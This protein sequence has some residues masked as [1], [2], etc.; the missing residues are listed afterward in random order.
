MSDYC[1][2]LIQEKD[3]DPKARSAAL[4][5]AYREILSW[6]IPEIAPCPDPEVPGSP[7]DISAQFF[8]GL[9]AKAEVQHG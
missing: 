8:L 4:A 9:P 7:I 5:A 3:V 1:V 2:S 6:P